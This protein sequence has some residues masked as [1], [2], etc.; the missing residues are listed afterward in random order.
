MFMNPDVV[1]VAAQ[2]SALYAELRRTPF[3]LVG[4]FYADG[5]DVKPLRVRDGFWIAEV[6][7]QAFGALW[8]RELRAL[9]KVPAGSAWWPGGALLLCSRDE[10]VQVGGS[11]PEF[12]LYYEDRDL[13]RRY[14]EAGLPMRSTA[15]LVARHTWGASSADSGLRV[16]PSGWAYL[17]GSNT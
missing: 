1:L 11:D 5:S 10:F 9:P 4:P 8:P 2:A 12:F 14:R 15:S 13:A 16:I 7:G 3:G 17:R 6:L